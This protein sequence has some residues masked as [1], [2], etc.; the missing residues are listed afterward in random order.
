MRNVQ[1]GE[2]VGSSLVQHQC[3]RKS[4]N[5]RRSTKS[6]NHHD[7]LVALHSKNPILNALSVLSALKQ[8]VKGFQGHQSFVHEMSDDTSYLCLVVE[9]CR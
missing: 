1:C 6:S 8:V 2:G 3:S 4:S 9:L 5:S 7:I